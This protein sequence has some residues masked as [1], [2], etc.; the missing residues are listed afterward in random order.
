MQSLYLYIYIQKQS[1][2]FPIALM[3]V[4]KY[5]SEYMFTFWQA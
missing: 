5:F 1:M 4:L 3:G 2:D